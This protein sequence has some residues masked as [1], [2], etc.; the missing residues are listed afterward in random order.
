MSGSKAARLGPIDIA[1]PGDGTFGFASGA[2]DAIG[3]GSDTTLVREGVGVFGMRTPFAGS[4]YTLRIYNTYTDASN[5]ERGKI[6]WMGNALEIG[7]EVAGTGVSRP[8][9]FIGNGSYIRRTNAAASIA[10][11]GAVTLTIAQLLTGRIIRDCAGAGRTDTFPT[12][13]AIVAGI[14]GAAVGDTFDCIITNGSDAAETITLAAGAGGTFDTN[15]TAAS[16][17]IPQNMQK[18][19][20]IRLTNV[21]GGTEAY[22]I[23]A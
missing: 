19:V 18:T 22:A 16:R 9:K 20:S 4:T 11:A 12:A 14:A 2:I 23:Y 21:G 3:A 15:Q 17:V 8:V 10:T 1:L 13:A 7:S 6:G 5:Y